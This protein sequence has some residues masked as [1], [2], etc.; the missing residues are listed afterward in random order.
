[1][2]AYLG[3]DYG[4]ARIGLAISET[5]QIA[6]PLVTIKNKG[7]GKNIAAIREIIVKQFSIDFTTGGGSL[8]DRLP[9]IVCGLP[10]L[11]DGAESDMAREVR[12]FGGKL[13]L[14]LCAEVIYQDEYLSS[15]EAEEYIRE[16]K[17]KNTVDEVAASIIL[18]SYIDGK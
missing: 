1:M 2:K 15:V 13:G 10:L 12:R 6:R 9:H 7:D 11:A 17:L 5:G 16:N 3:I 14:E 8:S 4:L 18:Q